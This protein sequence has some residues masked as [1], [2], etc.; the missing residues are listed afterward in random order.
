M[1]T[2]AVY[3]FTAISLLGNFSAHSSAV[4]TTKNRNLNYK[5]T[6]KEKKK[7]KERTPKAPEA[8]QILKN[9]PKQIIMRLLP[10]F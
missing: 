2:H 4:S 7:K 10:N 9:I 8:K 5:K 3:A 6:K 1:P